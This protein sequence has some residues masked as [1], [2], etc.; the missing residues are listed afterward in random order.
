MFIMRKNNKLNKKGS[1]FM[2]KGI[3]ILSQGCRQMLMAMAKN[4]KLILIP[5]NYLL[6]CKKSMDRLGSIEKDIYAEQTMTH[7]DA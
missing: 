1:S 4:C 3:Q 5:I 2:K 6:N 7:L